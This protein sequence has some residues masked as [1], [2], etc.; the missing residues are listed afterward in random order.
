MYDTIR[1]IGH[2][3]PG[4]ETLSDVQSTG[5]SAPEPCLSRWEMCPK[6]GEGTP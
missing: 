5:E 6:G 1:R 4:G 2:D 3:P